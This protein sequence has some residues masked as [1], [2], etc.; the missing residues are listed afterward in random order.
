MV[1]IVADTTSSLPLDLVRKLDIP[2]LPQIVIFGDESYRDDTELDARTFLE[3]LKKSPVLPKT[4]AP[5]PAL[6]T[7]I[8]QKLVDEGHTIIVLTPSRDVS[9]TF[10]SAEVAAAD[11]PN[12][13]IRVVDTRLVASN[14]GNL[15]LMAHEWAS[16]G[17]DPDTI[18]ANVHEMAKRHR[19]FI[20]VDTLEFLHKGGRIGGAQMLVGS[21]LQVKPILQF[22]N[23]RV[24]P[25]EQ[26][27]TKRRAIARIKELIMADCPR[28]P[29]SKLTVLH[30]GVYE[31]AKALAADLQNML[32]IDEV[33]VNDLPAAILVHAGP[34]VLGAT[35]FVDKS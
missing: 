3:K 27:R 33:P 18:I 11:F 22:K 30:G 29:E 5:P 34:G 2:Y 10:R 21:L 13:D 7:P 16:Q 17:M 1:K 4:A 15:V 8:F 19:V 26:Q 12:A 28:T 35:Y 24:E 6:Y 32:G 23:G 9:G 25:V 14:L 20:A 31:E